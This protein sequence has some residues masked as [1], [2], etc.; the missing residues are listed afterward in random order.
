MST[1]TCPVVRAPCRYRAI[2]VAASSTRKRSALL[3]QW[4]RP[5]ISSQ[6]R[7]GMAANKGTAVRLGLGEQSTF[8]DYLSRRAQLAASFLP[9]LASG[10]VCTRPFARR[11]RRS[12]RRLA[13]SA[14]CRSG[15]TG[16]GETIAA[17]ASSTEGAGNCSGAAGRVSMNSSTARPLT[18]PRGQRHPGAER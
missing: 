16:V 4:P 3:S 6:G 7:T 18:G 12:R 1:E 9:S 14:G 17:V 10:G 2:R 11:A 13:R 8:R 15:G 5:F